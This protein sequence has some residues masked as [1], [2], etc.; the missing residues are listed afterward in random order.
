MLSRVQHNFLYGI[1]NEIVFK[2]LDDETL[3]LLLFLGGK[4]IFYKLVPIDD[5]HTKIQRVVDAE[6]IDG[7]QEDLECLWLFSDISK[8]E[9]KVVQALKDL[10]TS[11][12]KNICLFV[13]KETI[14]DVRWDMIAYIHSDFDFT[15]LLSKRMVQVKK[16]L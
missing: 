14:K 8:S 13:S 5:Q 3:D 11:D 9:R 16:L 15:V 7:M 6:T 10:R 1:T 2:N 4:N 12:M